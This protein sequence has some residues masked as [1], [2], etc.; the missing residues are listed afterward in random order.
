MVSKRKII[1]SNFI[2]N[3]FIILLFT[4]ILSFFLD[5][6]Y[7]ALYLTKIFRNFILPFGLI[8]IIFYGKSLIIPRY[9]YLLILYSIFLLLWDIK[10]GTF[11]EKG[12][13]FY[14]STRNSQAIPLFFTLLIIENVAFDDRSIR[15]AIKIIEITIVVSFIVSII[16]VFD[17]EFFTGDKWF[18]FLDDKYTTR[19]ISIYGWDDPLSLGFNFIPLVFIYFLYY[20]KKYEKLDTYRFI[21]LFACII[22]SLLSNARWVV[23]STIILLIFIYKI[24]RKNLRRFIFIF[25]FS[26]LSIV[27]FIMFTNVFKYDLNVWKE[28]RLLK[29]ETFKESSRYLAYELFIKYF[30][31]H[32]F[33]GTGVHLTEE[34]KEDA[35]EG[36][37]SQIHVGFLAHLVS[38][39][40]IGSLFYFSFL[41]LIT[42]RYYKIGKRTRY[43]GAFAV[44]LIFIWGNMTLVSYRMM[45]Y[46]IFWALIFTKYFLRKEYE[47]INIEVIPENSKD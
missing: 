14:Y 15:K 17:Q 37:S 6:L 32:P 38:Y 21:L 12:F 19:R 40:I 20:L 8:F 26:I 23:G 36:G 7:P 22:I 29:E 41:F 47:K 45:F 39:G 33:M 13:W 24:Y 11:S 28:E 3:I 30:P 27:V 16:Q 5:S 18:I 1:Y 43:L 44:L 46:G 10:N 25:I 42:K 31:S 35:R 4:P 9:L 2:I 34:Q